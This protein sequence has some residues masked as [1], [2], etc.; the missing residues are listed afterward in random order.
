VR[1]LPSAAPSLTHS[2]PVREFSAVNLDCFKGQ[3]VDFHPREFAVLGQTV[4]AFDCASNSLSRRPI[5]IVQPIVNMQD[6]CNDIDA[7]DGAAAA[8]LSYSNKE[9]K[10]ISLATDQL[11]P[12]SATL[13]HPPIQ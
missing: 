6:A 4:D 13:L 8:V 3:T 1:L 7:F 9:R 12:P 2:I 5:H 11:P 10:I